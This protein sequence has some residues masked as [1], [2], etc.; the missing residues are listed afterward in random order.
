[1]LALPLYELLLKVLARRLLLY[2][3]QTGH[4]CFGILSVLVVGHGFIH[5]PPFPVVT[6]DDKS[7]ISNHHFPVSGWIPK[8]RSQV[9]AIIE[10]R[11]VVDR[12][13][14]ADLYPFDNLNG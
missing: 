2:I 14:R 13:W 11:R 5:F 12:G 6:S 10:T 4:S 3:W 9:E 7:S 1:V 8:S